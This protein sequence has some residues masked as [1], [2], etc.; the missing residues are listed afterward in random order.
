MTVNMGAIIKEP[1]S[2]VK[3]L[4]GSWRAFKPIVTNKCMGCGI[5]EWYCPDLAI[6]IVDKKA[7][8][9]YDHCK[10]CLICMNECPHKAIKKE[11]EK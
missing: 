9:D 7:R 11:I 8:I 1:G 4:T 2:S 6:K 5:C 3:N 10:G